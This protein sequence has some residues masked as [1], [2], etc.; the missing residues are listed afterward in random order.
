[1]LC[2]YK[3]W[4]L[5]SYEH[6]QWLHNQCEQCCV[7][8]TQ[9]TAS[10]GVTTS[11]ASG[12]LL[13]ND[14]SPEVQFSLDHWLSEIH[15]VIKMTSVL[16]RINVKGSTQTSVHFTSW[17]HWC[18]VLKY[19]ISPCVPVEIV[20]IRNRQESTQVVQDGTPREM[21]QS[22][23]STRDPICSA[24][25]E[26]EMLSMS[27]GNSRGGTSNSASSEKQYQPSISLQPVTPGLL[28]TL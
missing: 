4:K 22:S 11:Q 8:F 9:R 24:I 6:P 27:E 18:D 14:R 1:M 2:V 5:P 21:T 3:M 15:F 17:Y 25:S 10:A 7:V 13:W 19:M 26:K 23:F 12:L 16:L 28:F 20:W